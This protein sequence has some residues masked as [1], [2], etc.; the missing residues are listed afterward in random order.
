MYKNDF[1]FFFLLKRKR[2][3]HIAA[4]EN[5]PRQRG[6]EKQT[7]GDQLCFTYESLHPDAPPQ[8][9]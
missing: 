5:T 1:F 4:P 9:L 2:L 7:E 8:I 3:Y 6:K